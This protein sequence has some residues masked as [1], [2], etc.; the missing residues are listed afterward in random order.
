MRI[1][2][3]D[4]ISLDGVVQAPGGKGE[5][6]EGGFRHG[7]WSNPYF[8]EET[9]GSAIGEFM[10]SADALLFGRR[11][12]DGMASSWPNQ[13]DDPFA[14]RMN[15]IRKY[16]VSRT[17]DADEAASRWNNTTV[18]GGDDGIAAVRELRASGGDG[19]AL[20]WGSSALARQLVENDLVDEYQLLVEPILLGGG[21][22]IFP[23]DG[24]ARPLELVSATQAKT[25]VLVCVYRPA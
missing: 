25:G 24:Q 3:T 17:L 10:E 22:S 8:D 16:V 6:D 19:D 9:M 2:L 4:F 13:V 11:T 7:G 14:E 15:A 18:L 12:W 1:I 5:D 23:T 20:I 21:K